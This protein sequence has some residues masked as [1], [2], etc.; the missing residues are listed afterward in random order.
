MPLLKILFILAMMAFA[1][2]VR[3]AEPPDVLVKRVTEDVMQTA[4]TDRAIRS[5]DRSRIVEVVKDKILPHLDFER[6]TRLA[7]GRHWREATPRQRQQMMDE[8]RTLMIYTYAGALSQISDQRLDYRP[9]RLSP[10]DNEAEVRFRVLRPRRGEPVEVS[11]RMIRS[12]DG[13]KVYDVNVLGVWITEVYRSSFSEEVTRNG[14]D[15]LISRLAERNREL[16]TRQVL[17]TPTPA[18]ALPGSG[19]SQG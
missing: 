14:V 10:D 1:G 11:Y 6:A 9:L 17:T 8:F 7:M 16:R 2:T 12:P 5:G 3:A 19:G 15:G 13:W 18:E 4:R